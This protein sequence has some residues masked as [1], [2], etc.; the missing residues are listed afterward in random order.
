VLT[1]RQ[2]RLATGLSFRALF[3]TRTE[4]SLFGKLSDTK[5]ARTAGDKEKVLQLQPALAGEP[6]HYQAIRDFRP[7][8]EP[9]VVEGWTH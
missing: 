6:R 7:K 1:N 9:K 8:G 4:V 5:A 2:R 3:E